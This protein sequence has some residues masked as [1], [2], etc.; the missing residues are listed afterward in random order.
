MISTGTRFGA[1]CPPDE[2]RTVDPMSLLRRWIPS[3]DPPPLMALATLGQD[4]YPRVRH[5]LLSAC[6]G[7]HIYFHTDS[8]SAKVAELAAAPRAAVTLAWPEVARQVVAHGDV[9]PAEPAELR[10]AY[11]ERSRYLQLLA[12]LNDAEHAALDT[13]GRHQRWQAFDLAHPHLEP[14]P[15]WTGYTLAPREITFW[16]GDAAG[17]SQR[18]RFIRDGTS[19]RT[20]VLPG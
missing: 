19:W 13:P 6:V 4:G 10:R 12:W 16:R 7:D 15:T 20:E 11:A 2:Q 14:P 1:D 18:T 9:R 3:G 17:P 8:R 5:V